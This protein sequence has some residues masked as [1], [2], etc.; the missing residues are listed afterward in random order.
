VTPRAEKMDGG[1]ALVVAMSTATMR[2]S[3]LPLP[4]TLS[5]SSPMERLALRQQQRAKLTST[6]SSAES[7]SL[8]SSDSPADLQPMTPR[9]GFEHRQVKSLTPERDMRSRGG[10]RARTNATNSRNKSATPE[11][12]TSQFVSK[13]SLTRTH[14]I[15]APA[16]IVSPSHV[17]LP[18]PPTSQANPDKPTAKGM[19]AIEAPPTRSF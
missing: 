3:S 6:S 7:S 1:G 19:A 5:H 4:T 2:P 13:R 18:P 8:S 16:R 12:K 14:S 17:D 15:R 9:L 11:R 10:A